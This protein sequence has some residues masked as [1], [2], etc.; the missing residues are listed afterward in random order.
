MMIN[1]LVLIDKDN[2]PKWNPSSLKDVTDEKVES[3]FQ[4]PAKDFRELQL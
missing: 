4:P 3:Y 2:K 1:D